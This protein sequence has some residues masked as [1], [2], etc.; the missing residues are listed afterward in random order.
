MPEEWVRPSASPPKFKVSWIP[1]GVAKFGGLVIGALWLMGWTPYLWVWIPANL[2]CSESVCDSW[3]L[4]SCGAFCI[5][6]HVSI[7]PSLLSS[8]RTH[9]FYGMK[10]NTLYLTDLRTRQ[11]IALIAKIHFCRAVVHSTLCFMTQT[12]SLSHFCCCLLLESM[13]F[14][15]WN[16]ILSIWQIS[17]L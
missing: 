7:L 5:V 4:Q 6:F 15:V 9:G 17:E 10:Q 11:K 8:L 12:N 16:E 2:Q 13:G 14:M 3:S 1:L